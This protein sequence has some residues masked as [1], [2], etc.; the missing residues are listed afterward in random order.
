MRVQE[1]DSRNGI[2]P[3]D[4]FAAPSAL[5]RARPERGGLGSPVGGRWS[6]RRHDPARAAAGL[7]CPRW[8]GRSRP[9]DSREVGT[10]IGRSLHPLPI[11]C[12]LTVTFSLL[13][14]RYLRRAAQ[15]GSGE[16]MAHLGHLYMN[17]WGVPRDPAEAVRWFR[18]GVEKRSPS[19]QV[20]LG[21]ALFEGLGTERDINAAFE[22]FKQARGS[23]P[24]LLA[25]P[26]PSESQT[27]ASSAEHA[28]AAEA[29][30]PEAHYMIG[31]FKL[32]ALGPDGSSSPDKALLHFQLAAQTG[33]LL[34]AYNAAG[35]LLD[36]KGG[37]RNCEAAVELLKVRGCLALPWTCR[38]GILTAP[39]AAAGC[40]GEGPLDHAPRGGPRGLP[41]RQTRRR[42]LGVPPGCRD[43][44]R[45]GDMS[46]GHPP[47]VYMPA[48]VRGAPRLRLH[49][50]WQSRTPPGSSRRASV[51][52][53]QGRP[54]WQPATTSARPDRGI[55]APWSQSETPGTPVR[56][57]RAR[58]MP[59]R[60]KRTVTPGR[61][62]QRSA[63][64]AWPLCTSWALGCLETSICPR[65][66]TTW[67]QPPP[68][69]AAVS[70]DG[71][72]P[73][74]TLLWTDAAN[75]GSP[76]EARFPALVARVVLLL[77]R[78]FAALAPTGFVQL[79]ESQAHR[80]IDATPAAVRNHKAR[81]RRSPVTRCRP[82]DPREL[83]V[84]LAQAALRGLLNPFGG[85]RAGQG[86][87]W[88]DDLTLG[89]SRRFAEEDEP[90]LLSSRHLRR[91]FLS[92][93][94]IW[95]SPSRGPPNLIAAPRS[96]TRKSVAPP[97]VPRPCCGMS[98][99]PCS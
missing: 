14:S 96:P 37:P 23:S 92:Q 55:R 7:W 19:A 49:C 38:L 16:A 94:R 6:G 15:R 81:I 2:P 93:G 90:D 44:L 50:R 22:L 76:Q 54:R 18:Q 80:W 3:L 8:T 75:S 72:I 87:G 34:A 36:G 74:S 42:S 57:H 11:T 24:W 17:G 84:P 46:R 58:T 30:H 79:A 66:T 53:A 25:R 78:A 31:V 62:G 86:E 1:T 51:R 73:V 10:A 88:A 27:C 56:V 65:G 70:S 67:P 95:P 5:R 13:D 71:L 40:I 82:P 32:Q 39:V 69:R 89:K 48:R 64:S 12:G 4:P 60:P 28:Q 21:Y 9:K 98:P 91:L 20:G 59:G 68:R 26:V 47:F 83:R 99:R 97:E 35:M 61:A 41:G 85:P 29:G 33:H 77:H 52:T 63:T 45:G 43:G